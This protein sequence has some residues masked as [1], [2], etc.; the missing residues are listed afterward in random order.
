ME[1]LVVIAIIG[2][3]LGLAIPAINGG[4]K[5]AR[6][7]NMR[8]EITSLEQAVTQYQQQYGDFPPDFSSWP[9]VQRH[10]RKAF[11]RMS[12]ND[13][14]LLYFMLHDDNGTPTNKADDT[15]QAA[16]LDRGEALTWVLNGYSSDI[17]RPFTGPGGP[18]AWT[19]DGTN[20]YTDAT[21]TNA[22]R[23]NPANFQINIDHPNALMDFDDTRLDYANVNAAL[24]MTGGNRRLSDD[25]DLFLS[26]STE[27]GGAPYVYFDSR[28]YAT[29]DP[30][31]NA[32]A[33][34]F[35]GYGSTAFGA[36]RPYLSGNSN[37]NSTGADYTSNAVALAAWQFVNPNTF[38][39]ISAGLDNSFGATASFD[40]DGDSADEPIYFQFPS[41][42]A[43][44]PRT[45]VDNPGSLLITG[46]NK[47][48]E[49]AFGDT[50]QQPADNITNFSQGTVVDDIP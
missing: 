40:V 50:E 23:Q 15:F 42:L 49:S 30:N 43:I 4:V 48:Q 12:T 8:L 47:Y 44:A 22:D 14:E 25:G 35:N 13:S 18:L 33:G 19:G 32:G 9:V 5:R 21:V 38:Q 28:T 37:P 27:T 3:L 46:V 45:D 2:I 16:Q 24:P 11:P 34:D 41:G 20:A 36:I 10:Y 29:F 17:Q 26:F 1:I 6:I 31:V 7:T 39:I